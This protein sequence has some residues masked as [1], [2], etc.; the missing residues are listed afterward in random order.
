MPR[1]GLLRRRVRDESRQRLFR[2]QAQEKLYPRGG[3]QNL[4]LPP[5]EEEATS[6][7]KTFLAERHRA[8]ASN[9]LLQKA[10]EG[11]LTGGKPLVYPFSVIPPQR[12]LSP[13][14]YLVRNDKHDQPDHWLCNSRS[15]SRRPT[16]E[17][18]RPTALHRRSPRRVGERRR[19]PPRR[20]TR[21]SAFAPAGGRS[22]EHYRVE[23]FLTRH[24]RA[25]QRP[26]R[27]TVRGARAPRRDDAARL[28][29]A[30]ETVPQFNL[31]PYEATVSGEHHMSVLPASKDSL[32]VE[33]KVSKAGGK[34]KIQPS[35]WAAAGTSG[36]WDSGTRSA[37]SPAARDKA[38]KQKN[39]LKG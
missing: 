22:Y 9:T 15:R 36:S 23:Q 3:A 12:W 31:L 16:Q 32:W 4:A 33:M 29:L 28:L 17:N 39:L 21:S 38:S 13:Q 8:F 20:S 37:T 35:S 27:S 2:L 6:A 7:A 11:V 19:R 24:G 1:R 34:Y 14:D 25:G 26:G 30:D 10:F 5:T 18:P